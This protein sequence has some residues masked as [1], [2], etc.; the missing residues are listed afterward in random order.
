[1]NPT[2]QV[3]DPQNQT[4]YNS[5]SWST[6][7]GAP[8]VALAGRG[9][10]EDYAYTLTINFFNAGGGD[11]GFN[12]DVNGD[13]F[14]GVIPGGASQSIANF[15]AVWD[16]FAGKT[17]PGSNFMVFDSVNLVPEPSSALLG[18]LGASFA[19]VRRRRA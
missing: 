8:T 5:Y 2:T 9:S 1:M 12:A 10:H 15:G 7:A 13:A 3:S 4:E 18:L 6:G 11:V 16:T 14:S 17:A 19:F